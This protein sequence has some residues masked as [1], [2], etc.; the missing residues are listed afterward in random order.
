M[1]RPNRSA[2]AAC[3]S[4]LL[5]LFAGTALAEGEAATVPPLDASFFEGAA[6]VSIDFQPPM[7]RDEPLPKHFPEIGITREHVDEARRFLVETA[8]PNARRVADGS[9]LLGL[10]MIFVHWGYQFAD[11]MDL[12]PSTY[13]AFMD[14]YGPDTSKWPHHISAPDSKPA[15]QL[16]VRSGEYVIA[17]TAQDAFASSNIGFVL[18]NLGVRN[19]VFVGG[20][21]GACLGG[22]ARSAIAAG[23]RIL[24]VKDATF[25]ASERMR[26]ENFERIGCHHVV[27][28]AEFERLV[29]AAL[30]ARQAPRPGG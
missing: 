28:T 23:Y 25:D 18:K 13:N 9:R 29:E 12:D 14:N 21:T 17:K 3:L 24:C 2:S 5:C 15:D 27:S 20:D 19:I 6:F 26:L 8:L 1:K 7:W 16:G 22:S 11:A 30:E 4:S 10:P